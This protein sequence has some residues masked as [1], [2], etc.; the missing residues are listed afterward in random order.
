LNR[1]VICFCSSYTV[2]AYER[3]PMTVG[4]IRVVSKL[5]E[6]IGGVEIRTRGIV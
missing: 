4:K 6:V 2:H 1:D 3:N 5:F